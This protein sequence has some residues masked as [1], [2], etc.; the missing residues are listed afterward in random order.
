MPTEHI[1]YIIVFMCSVPR[2]ENQDRYELAE[3]YLGKARL[4][5]YLY[6]LPDF[7]Q[8]LAL[9]SWNQR[10]AGELH[11][12]MGMAELPLRN[13]IDRALGELSRNEMGTVEW[14]GTA[15]YHYIG[16]RDTSQ[17]RLPSAI[18]PLIRQDVIKAH[19][20]AREA[21][22]SR[23]TQRKS[24]RTD[25]GYM[26]D[27]VLAQLTFGT[28][29]KLVGKPLTDT[30]TQRTQRLWESN[31][32]KAFPNVSGTE[33]GRIQIARKL[34]QLR[35]IRNREAH[36]E[37]LLYVDSENAIAAVMSLLAAIDIRLTH[38]WANP[39]AIR[40]VARLDPRRNE[41]I[42]TAAFRL[43]ASG[44]GLNPSPEQMLEAL[45]DHCQRF[46]G[47]VMFCS[48][49]RIGNPYA[50]RL[51]EIVLYADAQH[52][53]TGVIANQGAI[54]DLTNLNEGAEGYCCPDLCGS[55]QALPPTARW[56]AVNNLHYMDNDTSELMLL[57]QNR[58][59]E[60]VF[61][62]TQTNVVYLR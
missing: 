53:A 14:T 29:C 13:A 51:R 1:Q 33:D 45:V 18:S 9:H 4:E 11:I 41:P 32:S 43:N 35:E 15:S 47:K 17:L 46:D 52:I 49:D 20:H 5:R 27:D 60:Q 62:S 3:K 37:N 12:L 61:E 44:C 58:S 40:R 54:A 30:S 57:D 28:W 21:S 38:G 55:V 23:F 6:E 42:R 24:P 7:E 16:Q 31:L 10:Y 22:G 48:A 25:R 56:F 2:S 19:Q 26:H 50:G 36:H 8:A 39:D 59:L 34:S